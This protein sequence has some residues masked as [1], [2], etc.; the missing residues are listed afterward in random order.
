VRRLLRRYS[1]ARGTAVRTKEPL[2]IEQLPAILMAM[3]DDELSIRD[4]ALL[5]LGCWGVSSQRARS[6]R[7]RNAAILKDGVLR[8]DLEREERPRTKGARTLRPTAASDVNQIGALRRRGARALACDRRPT[9]PVFRT[10]DLSRRHTTTRLDSGD[11][12]RVLRRRSLAA[13]V[14]GDFAGHS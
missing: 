5:L 12:P 9:G 14:S 7:R 4:R 11:V 6:A 1:R 10:F 13:G 8:L 3:A 2:L